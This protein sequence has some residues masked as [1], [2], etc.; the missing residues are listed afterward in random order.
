MPFSL[1][2]KGLTHTQRY[3]CR[4]VNP[5]ALLMYGH[6]LYFMDLISPSVRSESW[7]APQLHSA[8]AYRWYDSQAGDLRQW[9]TR[10]TLM[11]AGSRRCTAAGNVSLLDPRLIIT[12]Q[13]ISLTH[14]YSPS[15]RRSNLLRQWWITTKMLTHFLSN[16][17]RDLNWDMNYKLI[18]RS[19]CDTESSDWK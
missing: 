11:R 1:T 8:L 15:S 4:A 12:S 9:E 2:L 17:K 3:L 7:P 5:D 6:E 13:F 19:K 14:T 10:A 16:D 18:T